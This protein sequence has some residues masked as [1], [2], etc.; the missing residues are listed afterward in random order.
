MISSSDSVMGSM[1]ATNGLEVQAAWL[2][3]PCWDLRGSMTSSSVFGWRCRRRP[4]SDGKGLGSEDPH[5]RTPFGFAVELEARQGARQH[6]ERFL[7]LGS[8]QTGAQAVV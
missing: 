2:T 8:G 7:H 3:Y 5:G 6:G 1:A 4:E